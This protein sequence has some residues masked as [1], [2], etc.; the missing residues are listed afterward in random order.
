MTV[1]ICYK[2]RDLENEIVFKNRFFIENDLIDEIDKILNKLEYTY[3]AENT[4]FRARIFNREKGFCTDDESTLHEIC[5]LNTMW[6]NRFNK[7]FA[8]NEKL[9]Q[10]KESDCWGYDA[11]QSGAPEI[12]SSNG[13]INPPYIRV[14]YLAEDAYTAF[15]ET[16][17]FLNGNVSIAKF[18]TKRQLSVI[19]FSIS[20]IP[21]ELGITEREASILCY[22]S[23]V[24][25]QRPTS[26]G[27]KDYLITQYI[28]EYIRRKG[29]DGIR[30]S[31]SLNRP[32]INVCLFNP[33]DCL[34]IKSYVYKLNG[35]KLDIGIAYP[36]H[37]D[38]IEDA[39]CNDIERIIEKAK[40]E[41]NAQYGK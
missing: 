32:G 22:L 41:K 30:Y 20:F 35:L 19:N 12:S 25:F 9:N 28:S 18:E 39:K 4:F 13:R 16:R 40:G 6:P 36:G 38:F 27:N 5:K 10:C 1:D 2:F 17:P 11:K 33:D 21:E 29:Y 7:I 31:S 34:F 8:P 3:N 26:R 23:A 15:A 24:L 37:A 14:L